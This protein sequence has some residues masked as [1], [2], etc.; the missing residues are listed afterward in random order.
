L[1]STGASDAKHLFQSV[2]AVPS[3]YLTGV[4][5]RAMRGRVSVRAMRGRVSVRAMRGRVSV[6]AMRG[7]VSVRAMR[8]YSHVWH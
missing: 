6:R 3:I 1:Q 4:S 8:M 5:V 2:M 7:R